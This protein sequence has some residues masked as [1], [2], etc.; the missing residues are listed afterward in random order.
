MTKTILLVLFVFPAVIIKNATAQYLPDQKFSPDSIRISI[1][2]LTSE[3][4][5]KHPGFYRYRSPAA[6]NLLKDSIV[7]SIR[8]SM[9]MLDIY[10]KLKPFIAGI[11]CLHTGISLPANYTDSLNKRNDLLPLQLLFEQNKAYVIRDFSVGQKL[12]TGTE[13]VSINGHSIADILKVLLPAIPSDGYNVTMKYQALYLLFPLWYR[14]MLEI[15]DTYT[16]VYKKG[17]QE[18]TTTVAAQKFD[19]LAGDNFLEEKQYDKPLAFKIQDNTGFLTIRTFAKSRIKQGHQ[20]FKK[21]IRHSFKQ[22]A[23]QE[24]NNLVLD[25]RYNTGGTDANAAYLSS[26]FFDQ[27][28]RYWDRIEVTKA[29]ASEIKGKYRL[30]YPKPLHKD[31]MYVWRKTW[32]TRE[33]DFYEPQWPSKHNFK[34]SVYVLMNGFCMSSCADLT[35]VLSKNS[36]VRFIGEE[37]GGG[38]QGNTSGMMPES[39]IIA[40]LKVQV[41]LQKYVNAVDPD[42]NVGHG[43]RPD[44]PIP[45]TVA[46]VTGGKDPYIEKALELIRQNESGN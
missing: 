16:V 44:F 45:L 30:F 38:F 35:A 28:Y 11:G 25:L 33:F 23:K 1:N 31:S 15:A 5:A 6:T 22:L 39:A 9:N 24:I 18:Y 7:A 29:I 36:R 3:L 27:P 17:G 41:P 37:T 20:K 13:I 10:K 19:Q 34:G 14:S 32:V 43:I 2:N 21:F 40:G 8:D 12:N 42:K 46:S 26:Y 4:A